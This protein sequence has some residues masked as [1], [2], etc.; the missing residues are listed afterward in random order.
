MN[1]PK[2]LS[3][4]LLC[5]VCSDFMRHARAEALVTDAE[6]DMSSGGDSPSVTIDGASVVFNSEDTSS[7]GGNENGMPLFFLGD[8]PID[9]GENNT[10]NIDIDY[11]Q[12]NQQIN[13]NTTTT[14]NDATIDGSGTVNIGTTSN[15]M[16]THTYQGNEGLVIGGGGGGG[17]NTPTSGGGV[18]SWWKES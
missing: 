3:G 7:F 4:I 2:F 1:S 17:G 18:M 8:Q 10:I 11:A 5:L 16:N 6:Y 14:F 15:Y 9:W 13:N 12:N